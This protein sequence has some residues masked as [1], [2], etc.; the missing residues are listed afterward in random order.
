MTQEF[1]LKKIN[2]MKNYLIEEINH[3]ETICMN[4][5]KFC[6]VLSYIENSLIVISTITVCFQVSAFAF[7]VGIPTEITSFAIVLKICVIATAIKQ[8]KSVIKKERKKYEK[9]VLPEK[10]KYYRSLNF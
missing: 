5:K 1:R 7:S 6:R 9:I 4:H 2:E 10:V 8:Y 3:I